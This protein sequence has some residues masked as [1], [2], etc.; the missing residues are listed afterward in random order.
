MRRS[1]L[2]P[3][4]FLLIG[5]FLAACST[6]P[7]K[8]ALP[9]GLTLDAVATIDK[10]TPFA[11]SPD[12]NLV[13]L[14]RNSLQYYHAPS[15]EYLPVDE[16]VPVKLAWST[17]GFSLA[18]LYVHGDEGRIV[19]YNQNGILLAETP[20]HARLTGL[21][22]LSDDEL[23][24]AGNRTKAYKFGVTYQSLVFRWEPGRDLPTE[25]VLRDTTLRVQTYAAWKDVLDHGPILATP[26]QSPVILYLHP[27]DPPMFTPYYRLIM[28]DLDSRKEQEIASVGFNSGGGRFSADGE[29]ILYGDGSGTTFL[30]NPWT[31]EVL[32]RLP[33]PG[34]RLAFSPEGESWI[35]DGAVS[36]N[37]NMVTSMSS[38][39]EAEFFRDGSTIYFRDGVELYSLSGIKSS[40]GT[41][42]V[43]EI[44]EKVRKLRSMKLQGVLTPQ[45]YKESM[46][47][48][49]SP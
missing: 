42:F 39:V 30:L 11:V 24:V 33:Y 47:R 22:W 41:M 15:K 36:I 34:I 7:I 40:A 6:T 31:E 27:I 46:A 37:S 21:S 23:L 49:I 3:V 25:Q 45:D 1:T 10:G 28:R 4:S 29:K 26:S 9:E 48:I 8:R 44:A 16:R 17:R 20:V 18:A 2:F 35:I 38:G 5:I 19:V 13:A 32:A 14:V 12:S 43:P